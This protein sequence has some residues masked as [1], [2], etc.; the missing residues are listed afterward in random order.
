MK[1]YSLL[2]LLYSF[3]ICSMGI[4]QTHIWTGNGGN[5]DWSNNLNWSANTV[6]DSSSD[7]LIP[8]G[9]GVS[10]ATDVAFASTIELSGNSSLEINDDLNI[11]S[12]FN[13][14]PSSSLYFFEGTIS[15]GGTINNQGQFEIIAP[16]SKEISNI[17]I[18]NDNSIWVQLSNQIHITNN[19]TINNNST[20]EMLIA[21]VGGFLNQGTQATLNNDGLLRKL[22]DGINPIGNFYLILD[23][24][25][26]GT[27]QVDE[28]ETFLILGGNIDL[29][30]HETGIIQGN[31]TYDITANFT[32]TGTFSPGNS[33]INTIG[34]MDVIN[35]FNFPSEATLEVD[36]AGND[37]NE[38]DLVRITGFPVLE[39]NIEVNLEY[40][41]DI[42]DEYTIITAN[43]ITSCNLNEFVYA[44]FNGLTYKFQ[45]LCNAEDVRLR[46]I[47]IL[48]GIHRI[49]LENISF[50][51]QPN[52]ANESVHF[53]FSEEIFEIYSEISISIS[54]Y[55]GQEIE[56]IDIVSETLYFNSSYFSS[57]L[58]LAQ[59]RSDNKVLA[60][61]KFLI[62]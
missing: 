23:I 5:G 12:Q 7:V 33:S 47:E 30:N 42:D 25:N 9:F 59:L 51:T 52:P 38:Y 50:F 39:G 26:F 10:I 46:V 22:N 15:G 18:N 6:P 57:G 60:T 37:Q 3:L 40:A 4:A 29:T 17:T 41:P 27:I 32:N 14:S 2:S 20:G 8:D 43:N 31:G 54:N 13:V 45:V 48:L 16:Q 19:T 53:V 11:G 56:Y 61:T 55:L 35:E 1:R 58:Y 34:T 21:S 28:D 49:D 24:N 36:I 62:K 44:T